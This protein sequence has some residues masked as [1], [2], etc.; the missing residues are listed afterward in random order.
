M[1]LQQQIINNHI[2]EIANKQNISEDLAFLKYGHSLLLGRS[3]ISF[4]V[5]D[6]VDGGQDK[7]IDAITIEELEGSADV[8]ITQA[9]TTD[10]FSSTKLVQ[11]GNGLR[12]VFEASRKELDR[13]P[14]QALRDKIIQ[15]RE[16]Q[17]ALGPS[18]LNI[19]VSFIA[20]SDTAK[21][22]D[23]FK[24]EMNR[25]ETE[26]GASVF[27]SF[28]IRALGTEELNELSK[29]R[30]RRIRSVN[31][32]LKIKYDS[33][34]SS[35]ISYYSQGLKGAVCTIP[36]N[37]IAKLVNAHPEGSVFDLNIRQY[38][39][40]RGTVNRDIQ[41]SASGEDSYEFWFLNNGIT[42]VCD[43]FDIVHD[44]DNPKL[45]VNN[46]QIVN[47]CQTASTLAKVAKEG[48]LKKD[49]NVIV[50]VYETKDKNLVGKIVLTTNNQNQ[51]TSRNLRSNDPIQESM[52]EA[53]RMRGYFYERKP[54]QF[55]S[56]ADINKIYTNE[57]V[58]QAYLAIVLKNPSDAR[59][60]RYKLWDELNP[61]VFS[62][63]S[64][65]QY[66]L[67]AVIVRKLHDWLRNSKHYSSVN[68]DERTL[69]KRG[70][71]HIARV[72]GF[73]LLGGDKWEV[74]NIVESKLKSI[75]TGNFEL[76]ELFEKSFQ[77]MMK[78]IADAG[79]KDDVEHG[80]KSYNTNRA[81]ESELYSK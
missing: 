50:R 68:N 14:N 51:I 8:Y 11:L 64:I 26:Y 12:W 60:R 61:S 2:E 31:A 46:L 71:Y 77:T 47:G 33:N 78:I 28:T 58:G 48:S 69:A 73:N 23:E 19:H 30:D 59:S 74:T 67:S 39:G 27:E 35:V 66:I 56:E 17:S 6:L 40:T 55:E 62:G 72:A 32:D 36:A 24:D 4:D 54:R 38:L 63:A 81:I 42:I 75:E 25:I 3:Y 15:Y 5:D 10:S 34:T 76:N 65:D 22:S 49:T 43:K 18:N 79:F 53:F 45:I 13:L 41:S 70:L 44:P 29:T 20:N 80:I 1:G 16:V 9:T 21:L 7:Q 37:E 52:E 57:E